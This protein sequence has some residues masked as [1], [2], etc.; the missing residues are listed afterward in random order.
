MGFGFGAKLIGGVPQ[1]ALA[2]GMYVVR[3]VS[4]RD[5]HPAFLA[6][7]LVPG[8][9]GKDYL[10]DVI[11]VGR[12][13]LL[14]HVGYSYPLRMP[15]GI[16]ISDSKGTAEGTLGGWVADENDTPY[17]LSCWHC[18]DGVPSGGI[19]N[20]VLQPPGGNSIAKIEVSID[21]RTCPTGTVTID[22]ILAKIDDTAR[23]GDFI[24]R[25]G[26]IRGTRQ[27][28]QTYVKV[29]KSGVTT[30]LTT[31]GVVHLSS[32]L[33]RLWA[34]LLNQ[35]INYE[36]QLMIQPEPITGPFVDN[37]DSGS[38]LVDADNYAVGLV[39]GGTNS[40]PY[41]ALATPI[42]DVINAIWSSRTGN[43]QFLGYI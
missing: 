35:F 20:D 38:V 2:I 27:I 12:P 10:T 33:T 7:R 41:M 15:G 1:E 40:P 37:G 14:H 42:V 13:Q 28:N 5:V 16:H 19:G 11:A 43:L 36:K 30:H 39:V 25:I 32:T 3:K 21:P 26:E 9:L 24:L 8:I 22:A 18:C 34:P 17:L 31:G 4:A 23:A 29:R 6:E